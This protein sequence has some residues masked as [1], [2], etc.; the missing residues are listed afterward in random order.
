MGGRVFPSISIF[1]QE[2]CSIS[3]GGRMFSIS[4]EAGMAEGFKLATV[5]S[6]WAG[7]LQ[8]GPR[9]ISRVVSARAGFSICPRGASHEGARILEPALGRLKVCMANVGAGTKKK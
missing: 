1:S 4:Q 2:G 7:F 9:G 8:A 6:A 5:V 3:H